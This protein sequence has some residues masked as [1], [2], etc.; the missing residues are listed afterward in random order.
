MGAV[1]NATRDERLFDNSLTRSASHAERSSMYS[2][3]CIF[4]TACV[5]DFLSCVPFSISSSIHYRLFFGFCLFIFIAGHKAASLEKMKCN[6]NDSFD[7]I[8][9]TQQGCSHVSAP[10]VFNS[11]RCSPQQ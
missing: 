10:H 4:V 3:S 5:V 11:P 1:T 8:P 7:H 2:I 9:L 6:L